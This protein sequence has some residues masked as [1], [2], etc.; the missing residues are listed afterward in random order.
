MPNVHITCFGCGVKGHYASDIKCLNYGNPSVSQCTRP[1]LQV[2]CADDDDVR[3]TTLSHLNSVWDREDLEHSPHE[4]SQFNDKTDHENDSSDLTS[5]V[6][7]QAEVYQRPMHLDTPFSEVD[8]N[9]DYIV[10]NHAVRV[11]KAPVQEY[12][13]RSSLRKKE[14]RL[15]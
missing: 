5:T 10:Y 1:Q 4:G 14:D 6:S 2:A 3:S 12:P 9:N 15:S 8:S 7:A 11:T 13:S